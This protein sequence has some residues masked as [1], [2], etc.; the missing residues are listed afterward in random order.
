MEENVTVT[1]QSPALD[2][3]IVATNIQT[4]LEV[5]AARKADLTK[6]V[7]AFKDLTIADHND[8]QG[9]NA[10]SLARK[11]LKQERIMIEKEGK[12]MRDPLTALSKM[13]LSKQ[14]E[15]IE[16][17][18]PTEELLAKK[19][20]DYEET[21][22]RIKKEAAE[23]ETARIQAMV[24]QLVAFNYPYDVELLKSI[25]VQ[26]FK[27]LIANAKEAFNKAEA[28]RIAEEQRI[29]KEKADAE[30]IARKE[31]E[32]LAQLRAD[33]IEAQ[34]KIDAANEIIAQQQ[35]ELEKAAIA[36]APVVEAIEDKAPEILAP[37]VNITD[38]IAG[39]AKTKQFK[40][41]DIA[42]SLEAKDKQNLIEL[43]EGM[44]FIANGV[45]VYSPAA[46]KILDDT[47]TLLLKVQKM[48]FDKSAKL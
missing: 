21:V 13:I 20:K 15:L 9:Y 23:K 19:E 17:T 31:K 12:S 26:D 29:A 32:E 11:I 43:A 44:L 33:K 38:Q 24:D 22:E 45:K 40:Q 30:E 46:Q 7:N 37:I 10:V 3:A 16:L 18:A 35:R 8:K 5:F 39:L 47:K 14:G 41:S 6:K 34:R 42:P 48:I 25:T 2:V 27:Y 1:D 28:L 4:G 36:T